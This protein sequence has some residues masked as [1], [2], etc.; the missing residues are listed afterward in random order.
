MTIFKGDKAAL[1]KFVSEFLKKW[2]HFLTG[3]LFQ[4]SNSIELDQLLVDY[5]IFFKEIMRVRKELQKHVGKS[6]CGKKRYECT[7]PSVAPERMCISFLRLI[8]MST[9]GG[10]A[11]AKY[12]YE[13]A[14]IKSVLRTATGCADEE[15]CAKVGIAVVQNT[16]YLS[17]LRAQVMYTH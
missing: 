16:L 9:L 3:N 2:N 17:G 7:K 5:D 12:D 10:G 11:K 15:S 13:A 6:N 1:V 14:S 4:L 8:I